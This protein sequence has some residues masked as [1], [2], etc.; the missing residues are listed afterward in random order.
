[1][2]FFH[3]SNRICIPMSTH[4][5]ISPLVPL[6]IKNQYITYSIVHKKKM[7]KEKIERREG[8]REEL[9]D[10][11]KGYSTNLDWQQLVLERCCRCSY[12][13]Y[14][15][16]ACVRA[17]FLLHLRLPAG[18]RRGGGNAE[19]KSKRNQVCNRRTRRRWS[20]GATRGRSESLMMPWPYSFSERVAGSKFGPVFCAV[21]SL[22]FF[23]FSVKKIV[24]CG[25]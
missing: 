7:K 25:L 3:T 12:H 1:M 14:Q 17:R 19:R 23:Y 13:S 20:G 22:Y 9:S 6:W 8:E 24:L 15:S 11:D 16:K 5:C 21:P 18:E 10:R 4:H 2:P